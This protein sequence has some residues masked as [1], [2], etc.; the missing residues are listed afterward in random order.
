[1]ASW[2]PA[3]KA[4]GCLH[5]DCQRLALPGRCLGLV[6][7]SGGAFWSCRLGQDHAQASWARKTRFALSAQMAEHDPS[8]VAGAAGG[9]AWPSSCLALRAT[10]LAVVASLTMGVMSCETHAGR[11]AGKLRA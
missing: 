10:R 7:A 8:R 4:E 1:M 2:G 11:I 6:A 3:A 9:L 5:P